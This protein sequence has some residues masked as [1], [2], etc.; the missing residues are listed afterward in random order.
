M[1][2]SELLATIAR[3]TGARSCLAVTS[4]LTGNPVLADLHIAEF[5]KVVSLKYSGFSPAERP[6]AF[7]MM[8]RLARPARRIGEF[9]LSFIDP[10]HSYRASLATFRM[11]GRCTR[12]DGWL[13]AHDCYPPYELSSDR[14]HEGPWC[15]ST[16]AAFRDFAIG[17]D[18]AWFVVGSD[19]G[20]GVLGPRGTGRLVRHSVAP[21]LEAAWRR[22]D[23]DARRELFRESGAT[24]MRL[25]AP[26]QAESIVATLAKRESVAIPA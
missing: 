20:L 16:Y 21:D 18:R 17:S 2:A 22:G 10:F 25:V 8:D 7:P 6:S 24:L 12:R 19:F 3:I 11:F 1:M 5:H 26:E 4:E 23:L 15:G 9:D 13:I 14:F